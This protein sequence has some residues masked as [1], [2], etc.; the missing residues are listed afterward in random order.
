MDS[1]TPETQMNEPDDKEGFQ[2]G[3]NAALDDARAAAEA[4][5]A[6]EDEILRAKDAESAGPS[7][8]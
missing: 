6:A 1:P 2:V 5:W 8:T 3:Y 4:R 7:S